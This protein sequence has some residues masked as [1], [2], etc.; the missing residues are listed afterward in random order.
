MGLSHSCIDVLD[1]HC[2]TINTSI[3]NDLFCQV[4]FLGNMV[5]SSNASERLRN[6]GKDSIDLSLPTQVEKELG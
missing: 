4:L 2:K 1:I 3:Q 6:S 5:S